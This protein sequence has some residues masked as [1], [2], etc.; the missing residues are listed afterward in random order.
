MSEEFFFRDLRITVSA[1]PEP[2]GWFAV[3]LSGAGGGGGAP[4]PPRRLR[5]RYHDL[6]RGQG[7]LEI[8]DR[9]FRVL[10]ARTR[11]GWHVAV[12]GR[13]F[14]FDL[15]RGAHAAPAADPGSLTAPMPGQVAKVLA[16]PGDAVR[17]GQTLL[18]IEAM[19]LQL[20]VRAP[21]AGVVRR[22]IPAEGA[23]VDAGA[24][25]VEMEPATPE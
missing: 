24:L 17:A 12:D 5:A 21:V 4:A 14:R 1:V 23:V 16:R 13:C 3:T 2:D 18:I 7:M 19:K 11:E 22:V 6:S 15:P 25:L 10:G 9:R 8:G 20:E